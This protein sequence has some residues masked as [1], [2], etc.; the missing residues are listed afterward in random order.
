MDTRR[1]IAACLLNLIDA[2]EEPASY[3]RAQG[4]NPPVRSTAVLAARDELVALAGALAKSD[5]MSVRGVALAARL[6][7]DRESPIFSPAADLNVSTWARRAREATES[8]G[9]G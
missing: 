1:Q 5:S 4:I 6:V 3:W 9:P 8:S 7:W 2:A